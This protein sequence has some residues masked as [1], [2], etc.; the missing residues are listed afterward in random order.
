MDLT[1]KQIE[2]VAEKL[3]EFREPEKLD[4]AKVE[5]AMLKAEAKKG[6][7]IDPEE[8]A[9]ML[10]TLYTPR[11]CALVDQLSNRQLKRL[12]KSM[13][14]YPIGKNYNHNDSTEAEAFNIGNRLV[15]AKYVL[16][17]NTYNENRE[18]IMEAA[19]K[20]AN[21]TEVTFGNNEEKEA[22]NG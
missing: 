21:E 5:A 14:E 19:E 4:P 6:E 18:V 9:S 8:I 3:A 17:V 20:A 11:F 1:E 13:I 2:D 10:L 7:E 16:M 22:T 12:I 15:D